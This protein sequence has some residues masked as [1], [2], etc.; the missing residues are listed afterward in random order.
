M[1]SENQTK[2]AILPAT[3][4]LADSNRLMAVVLA[5]LMG[6]ALL[7]GAGFAQSEMLHNAAHDSRHASGFPC[8]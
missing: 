6:V 7:Y 5:S 4:P 3:L 1:L 8:H 2:A